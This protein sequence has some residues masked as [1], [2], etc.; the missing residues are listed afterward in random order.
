MR[1]SGAHMEPWAGVGSGSWIAYV[2]SQPGPTTLAVLSFGAAAIHFAVS[3]DHFAEWAPYGVAFAC[4]AWFQILWAA[5]YL[6]GRTRP[7]VSAAVIVNAGTIVVWVW[8]RT[9]GLPI[10]PKSGRDGA[11]WVCRCP[12]QRFRGTRRPWTPRGRDP[13]RGSTREAARALGSGCRRRD[14]NGGRAD[15]HCPDG[16]CSAGDVDGLIDR[17]G[18]EPEAP[19]Q[20]ALRPGDLG[21]GR[22]DPRSTG[23][24]LHLSHDSSVCLRDQR[25]YVLG[26]LPSP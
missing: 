14:R 4:L 7:W 24:G 5:I 2:R 25:R 12:V 13:R 17:P 1:T 21:E 20:G 26:G 6:V 19:C 16:P 10:G 15:L 23:E 22:V 8:S 18:E 11:S 9:I 3:P